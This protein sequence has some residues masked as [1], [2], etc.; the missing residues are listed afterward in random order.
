MLQLLHK[1]GDSS[2]LTG[3]LQMQ[4]CT[5]MS[6]LILKF[7]TKYSLP[8]L[9]ECANKTK[10]IWLDKSPP[11]PCDAWPP[12]LLSKLDSPSEGASDTER[13]MGTTSWRWHMR[14]FTGILAGPLRKATWPT[15][16]STQPDESNCPWFGVKFI[17]KR[18]P[19]LAL[20]WHARNL[21]RS[22]KTD[23][24][25]FKLDDVFPAVCTWQAALSLGTDNPPEASSSTYATLRH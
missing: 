24:A 21:L 20:C 25:R 6:H 15:H 7:K 4:S 19:T 12:I 1:T 5:L 13:L 9:E 10:T 2:R 23:C 17:G 11:C 3:L 14:P 18:K 8:R 16:A 22:C